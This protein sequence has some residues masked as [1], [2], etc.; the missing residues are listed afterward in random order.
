MRFYYSII[1][2][3][4]LIYEDAFIMNESHTLE[5]K[6]TVSNTFLKTVSAFANYDGGQII[7]GIR[8][9]GTTAGLEDLTQAR[10]DIENRINDSIDPIPDYYLT[11]D[12]ENKTLTLTVKPGTHKPYFYRA[13]A[14]RRSDTATV[15]MDRLELRRLILEGSNMNYEELT[16]PKQDLSFKILEEKLIAKLGIERLDKNILKTLELYDDSK[17][18]NNAALLLADSNNCHGIDIMRFGDTMDIILDHIECS[19]VSILEMYDSAVNTYRQYYQYEKIS[20]ALREREEMIP[21]NAFREAV[22]NALAHRRWDIPSEIKISLLPDRIIITSPGGLPE[23]MS[24]E[25]YLSGNVSVLRNPITG[26]V[27]FRLDIIERFGTGIIRIKDAYRDS[28]SKPVFDVFE[29]SLKITL[30]ITGSTS[31]LSPDEYTVYRVLKNRSMS[32]SE[33]ARECGFSSS[34]TLIL[35]NRLVEQGHISRTGNGRGTRYES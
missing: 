24:E 10:I 26:N 11:P 22:A 15:E 30:P 9:D 6:E 20:G 3:I 4:T 28:V 27:L 29:N 12:T 13:K 8:D 16:S 19:H 21:E 18:F 5:F 31:D 25:E 2:A 32:K 33:I 14:Y 17:G 7:F 35:L 1:I 23:N 34:K